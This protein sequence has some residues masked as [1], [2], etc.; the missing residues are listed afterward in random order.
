MNILSSNLI[1]TIKSLIDNFKNSVLLLTA[2]LL[3]LPVSASAVLLT[4][5]QTSSGVWTYDLT[6]EPLDNY[7]IFQSST[8]IALTGLFGVTG[9]TGPTS[10]DFSPT[11]GLLDA[12]NLNWTA[13][14]LDGGTTVQWTHVGPGTGN[15]NVDKHVY[16]FQ[17]FATGATDGLASYVTDGFERDTSNPLSGGSFDLDVSGTV[18][19]P[20]NAVPE[21]SILA[22]LA[23]GLAGVG[24]VRRRKQHA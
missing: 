1:M 18:I 4:G 24:F 8:T 15:F 12:S 6:Y 20:V 16:G 17:I 5:S 11:G 7:S 22:L 19:G 3:F 13:S 2:I 9:A 10:T 14:I 21:P 23:A